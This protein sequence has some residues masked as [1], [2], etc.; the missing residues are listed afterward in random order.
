MCPKI[1]LNRVEYRWRK[2]R[3][4]V[5]PQFSE[6]LRKA[7]E[8]CACG[9]QPLVLLVAVLYRS[10]LLPPSSF[11][12]SSSFFL[13]KAFSLQ[14]DLNSLSEVF[15]QANAA[16]YHVRGA[17]RHGKDVSARCSFG[18]SQAGQ[19]TFWCLYARLVLCAVA[20]ACSVPV[21]F[22]YDRLH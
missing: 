20:D 18:G 6:R 10:R 2:R 8:G 4:H 11:L 12:S 5:P 19:G 1:L 13:S 7:Q 15:T 17:T 22:G 21:R 3:N 14:T 16:D 9:A